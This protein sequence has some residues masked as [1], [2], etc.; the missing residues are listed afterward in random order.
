[1]LGSW[2]H[3]QFP[4]HGSG[5]GYRPPGSGALGCCGSGSGM[6]TGLATAPL[7]KRGTKVALVMRSA[8]SEAV[9]NLAGPESRISV[10]KPRMIVKRET[11]ENK[12][13]SFKL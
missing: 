11:K 8:V 13:L 1:M 4:L 9:V 5:S 2:I 6:A 3:E 12:K 7:I 10:P